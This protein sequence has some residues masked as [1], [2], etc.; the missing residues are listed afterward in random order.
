MLKLILLFTMCKLNAAHNFPSGFPSI[1]P[2]QHPTTSAPSP[3]PNLAPSTHPSQNPTTP[4]T[5]T[6]TFHLQDH[7]STTIV[8]LDLQASK[9]SS[10]AEVSMNNGTFGAVI[11]ALIFL[12]SCACV[13]LYLVLFVKQTKTQCTPRLRS[14][15]KSPDVLSDIW[16]DTKLNS[17]RNIEMVDLPRDLSPRTSLWN[18]IPNVDV[19][20]EPSKKEKRK[21]RLPSGGQSLSLFSKI[22]R[23]E[24]FGAPPDRVKEPMLPDEKP[25]PNVVEICETFEN[26]FN[27]TSVWVGSMQIN[28]C[29]EH[30][31]EL[32]R[33]T[34]G[35]VKRV[36]DL[37]MRRFALPI[38]KM[39]L[40]AKRIDTGCWVPSLTY[41]DIHVST[42]TELTLLGKEFDLDTLIIQGNCMVKKEGETRHGKFR[43]V[44]MLL[45]QGAVV[46]SDRR[47]S[48][49][50]NEVGELHH[51]ERIPT[52]G[53]S[54]IDMGGSV[55]SIVG[56]EEDLWIGIPESPQQESEIV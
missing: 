30:Y 15:P 31:L 20:E 29:D 51:K 52:F 12:A 43:I 47:R 10:N 35:V 46:K 48:A 11:I 56:S 26:Y 34:D 42:G 9:S 18:Q 21:S 6:T 16:V 28:D 27:S 5:P 37:E 38:K 40:E 33:A 14:K 55:L 24:S 7:F 36:V 23:V 53:N 1:A 3:Y 45:P 39:T 19:S 50:M 4:A 25:P 41:Q 8:P 54:L 44:R 13:G 2:S 17:P 49:I 32:S 22:P